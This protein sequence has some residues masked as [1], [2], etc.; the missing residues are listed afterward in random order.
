MTAIKIV[1]LY[2]FV[3]SQTNF[4]NDIFLKN[5]QASSRLVI[6]VEQIEH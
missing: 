3:L 2:V 6:V 5:T 4:R 1:K